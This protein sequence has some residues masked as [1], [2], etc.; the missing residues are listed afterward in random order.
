M[1]ALSRG[2]RVSH[3]EHGIGSVLKKKLL[4]SVVVVFDKAPA[5]PL[6]IHRSELSLVNGAS[7][8]PTT[9]SP[10]PSGT[11]A[12]T[13][14]G[15]QAER[16]PDP[17]LTAVLPEPAADSA[18]A[19][20]AI[21]STQ[22]RR[23]STEDELDQADGFQILEA[24]RLGVV[25]QRGVGAYAVGRDEEVASIQEMLSN[26]SGCRVI[27]GDYGTGKTHLLDVAEQAARHD[28]FATARVVLDP[29]ENALHQPLS[30]YKRIAEGIRMPD[31]DG[32][33]LDGILLELQ[34]SP[35]HSS[36]HGKRMS[37]FFSS[38]LYVLQNGT[39]EDQG[40][41]RDY[42]QGDRIAA[43]EL[44]GIL[45]GLSW[46]D[47]SESCAPTWPLALSRFRTY[48]RMYMHMIGTLSSWAK[49]AGANGLVLFFDEVERVDAIRREDRLY[50][51]EVLKHY[52]AV[53]M[54]EEDLGFDPED[55]YKG[56]QNVHRSLPLKFEENQPLSVVFALTP[57]PEIEE[58]FHEITTEDA[59]DIRLRPLTAK[60]V[61]DL[62]KRITTIYELAY[63][64]S[65]AAR[66]VPELVSMCKGIFETGTTNFRSVVRTCVSLLDMRRLHGGG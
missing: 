15:A 22:V 29:S 24:M 7:P 62:A 46:N 56:G 38:Y 53:T 52:A 34:E 65:E 55:L 66:H 21:Q 12:I 5:L 23:V 18:A 26:G 60:H 25:P 33:G 9:P 1:V 51:E 10:Q 14:D 63:P 4:R 6:T 58:A 2:D 49:D 50:A 16:A 44:R 20:P 45:R 59:Y 31:S 32:V 11:I 39:T 37:R 47:Y 54:D 41:F 48:G 27:W 40:W 64:D 30:L 13:D 28:G 43:D 17:E 42:V 19:L 57:L 36:P 61:P 35:E 8:A 3:S